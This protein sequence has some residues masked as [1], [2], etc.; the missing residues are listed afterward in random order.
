VQQI[1]VDS[2]FHIAVQK[3]ATTITTLRHM[4]GYPNGYDSGEA[5]HK[6]KSSKKSLSEVISSSRRLIRKGGNYQLNFPSVPGFPSRVCVPGFASTFFGAFLA[7]SPTHSQPVPR[8][9]PNRRR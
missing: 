7:F 8:F 6:S 9:P 1:Q 3:K 2:S 4:V 5:C